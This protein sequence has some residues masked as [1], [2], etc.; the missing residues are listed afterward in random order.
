[1]T[2]A[3]IDTD[4][5]SSLAL[6]PIG[7][8]DGGAAKAAV[9]DGVALWLAGGWAAFTACDA[10]WRAQG[11]IRFCALAL[12]LARLTAPR[13][14]FAG[15][16]L[17]KP[18]VMGI[19]NATPDSFHVRHPG[20]GAAVAHGHALV[21][22]GADIIDVGGESTRPGAEP[23]AE[24]AELARVLPVLRRLAGA[25]VPISIDTRHV[26][27]MRAALAAGARI[28]NDVN[29][30]KA[31]G[32]A[33]LVA[34]SGASA[35]VMH[36]KGEPPTMNVDP[37]YG[38]APYEIF[39]YLEERIEACV[40]AGIDRSRLAVDPGIGFG[41][42]VAHKRQV[43]E[44]AALYH[45][46]GCAVLIGA[47]GKLP[48]GLEASLAAAVGAARRGV[49]IVRVHDVAR[50]RAALAE[51]L[52]PPPPPLGRRGIPSSPGPR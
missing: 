49:Q 30:L 21:A 27:V 41:M 36:M 6:R 7:L 15:L 16:D 4:D 11:E 32:A 46:T 50:T 31:P 52:P 43:L 47:S 35:V 23:V 5:P 33:E 28:V 39:R 22:E 45:A 3:P 12:L 17:R 18:R 34:T 9:G 25:T 48:G 26:A 29:A 19:V 20:T 24:E 8:L 51:A 10:V 40:A 14:P 42:T 13:A 37:R 1:V 44:W 38:H 2:A